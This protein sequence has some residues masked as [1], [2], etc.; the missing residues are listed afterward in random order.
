MPLDT[1]KERARNKGGIT[2]IGEASPELKS[3]AERFEAPPPEKETIPSRP[4][5]PRKRE[6]G[7]PFPAYSGK[8]VR[9]ELVRDQEDGDRY[10]LTTTRPLERHQQDLAIAAGFDAI[11]D[12]DTTL[13]WEGSRENVIKADKDL[14]VVGITLDGKGERLGRSR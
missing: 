6:H 4:T 11:G 13:H 7:E 1:R 3:Y 9:I 12:M 2:T 8:Y 14:N 5:G 10:Y